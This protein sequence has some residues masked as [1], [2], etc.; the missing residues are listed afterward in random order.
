MIITLY[1]L[2]SCKTATYI[3]SKAECYNCRPLSA[4][5]CCFSSRKVHLATRLPMWF[6]M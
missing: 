1:C 6:I 4:V 3:K 2:F 5:V